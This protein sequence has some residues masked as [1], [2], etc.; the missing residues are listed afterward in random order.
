[1][2]QASVPQAFLLWEDTLPQ[3]FAKTSK[4]PKSARF[5]FAT[6]IDNLALDLI[7]DL[8]EARFARRSRK[9]QVLERLDGR[10]SRLRVLVRIAF[11][12][13]LLDKGG[14]E[15][16]QRRMDELGRMVGAWRQS[17]G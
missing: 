11:G 3:L 16:L 5:T 17:V 13:R 7:E 2:S 8:V 15:H 6:R 14:Y 1:M 4:F 10:L 12:Q 9:A